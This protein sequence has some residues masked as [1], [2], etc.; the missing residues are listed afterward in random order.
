MTTSF[1]HSK[2]SRCKIC[3]EVC[4][5]AVITENKESGYPEVLAANAEN[6][7]YCGHCEAVCPESAAVVTGLRLQPAFFGGKTPALSAREIGNYIRFRR[8]IRA[9]Q[10][11]EVSQ[12]T[13]EE[14]LDVARYAPTAMN[15]QPVRWIIVRDTAKVKALVKMVIGWM[16]KAI[17]NN[18]PMAA[19]LDFAWLVNAYESGSDPI[20]RNAPHL[21]VTY[22]HK[23]NLMAA[24][25]SCIALTTFDLTAPAFGL[26]ACWAGFFRIAAS[27]SPEIR[28]ELGIPDDH[29]CTGAL[30]V[31]FP[32]YRYWRIP[33]RNKMDVTWK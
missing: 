1:D 22:S 8:S 17:E 32:K 12:K 20:L 33:K 18:N 4:P 15:A 9:Y 31:G 5:A 10:Q 13:L 30:M 19:V 2:C 26:G 27:A 11:K 24:G 21:A 16:Q 6:C 28:K 7:I 3:W 25:D 29:V 14:L 23:D